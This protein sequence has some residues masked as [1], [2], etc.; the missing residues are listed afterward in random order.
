MRRAARRDANHRTVGDY[1][2]ALGWSVLDLADAGDGVPDYAVGKPGFAALVE[3]KDGAK[4]PS[5]RKLTEK[6][7]RVRDD[8]QGPY[9][10]ALDGPDAATQLLWLF[11]GWK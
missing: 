10:I 7:Q 6:E 8:W 11:E 5:A 9:V 1:L 2:R 3:V 4:P